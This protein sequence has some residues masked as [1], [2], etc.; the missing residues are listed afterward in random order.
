MCRTYARNIIC[1]LVLK[2]LC[3]QIWHKDTKDS[4]LSGLVEN[5]K[6]REVILHRSDFL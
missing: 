6:S 4:E 2:R 1:L 5:G 3:F